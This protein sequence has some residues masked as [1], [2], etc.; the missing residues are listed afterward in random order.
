MRNAVNEKAIAITDLDDFCVENSEAGL[1]MTL[2]KIMP[3]FKV[4][5]FTIPG[6]C[7]QS[8]IDTWKAKSWVDLVP[9]GWH[10]STSRECEH[11]T[12]EES[13]EYLEKIEPM[14]MTKGF[15][16]PG[17][18]ISNGMYRA[19][20]ERGY[21]VA[22]QAYN[23]DRRPKDLPVYLLEGGGTEVKIH[24]HIGHR[25]GHNNNEIRLIIEVILM[26]SRLQFDFVKDH[27]RTSEA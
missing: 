13:I 2:H 24:G 26:N 12:Y 9:H 18:L 22:D 8:F 17:W 16:A 21:W 6:L 5:L 15:K 3:E 19:L 27:V 25:G 1:L 4:T 11:W 10:H 20:L 23:N 14:G 7:S